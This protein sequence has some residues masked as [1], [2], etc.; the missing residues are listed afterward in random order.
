VDG[1]LYVSRERLKNAIP[2]HRERVQF[3]DA[4]IQRAVELERAGFP[5]MGH[6][7]WPVP[8][9]PLGSEKLS[10]SRSPDKLPTGA[11]IFL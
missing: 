7:L 11:I 9:T 2:A 4:T 5:G 6:K 8:K 3:G 10:V 1:S